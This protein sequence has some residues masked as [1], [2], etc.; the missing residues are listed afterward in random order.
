[1]AVIIGDNSSETI[2]GTS[3][4]DTIIA[5]DGVNKVYAGAGDDTIIGGDDRDYLWGGTGDDTI[6]GGDGDDIISGQKG[7]DILDGGDGNDQMLGGIGADTFIISLSDNENN[8]LIA[9]VK[10][11]DAWR[12]DY[13]N[14]IDNIEIQFGTTGSILSNV[15]VSSTV[16]GY[17]TLDTVLLTFSNGN[18][19]EI[20]SKMSET[21]EAVGASSYAEG[22]LTTFSSPAAEGN[23]T[24]IINDVIA[25]N[26]LAVDAGDGNDVVAGGDASQVINGGAGQD[27]INGGGG[28]DIISGG[29]DADTFYVADGDGNDTILDFDAT[30]GD[31][32]VAH[33]AGSVTV[34]IGSFNI[35]FT[36]SGNTI[37]VIGDYDAGA[38]LFI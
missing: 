6:D 36:D 20:A 37:S 10:N 8:D 7:D 18:T 12:Y 17:E 29:S 31:F 27:F 9:G 16:L 5:G 28:D 11:G 4:N 34:L 3:G 35:D 14:G 23:G 21:V 33:G 1:M 19:L 25:S 13:E 30:E 26:A 22:D 2:N 38:V 24:Q 32:I 15:E